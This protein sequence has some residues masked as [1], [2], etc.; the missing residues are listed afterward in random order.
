MASSKLSDEVELL[1]VIRAT[2]MEHLLF[3]SVSA[4]PICTLPTSSPE[5][6]AVGHVWVK[7]S[8]GQHQADLTLLGPR[9]P[10]PIARVVAGFTCCSP[11][12]G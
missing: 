6:A 11:Q 9:M 10:V 5:L 8:T 3:H 4:E 2:D 7:G 1:S 12:P